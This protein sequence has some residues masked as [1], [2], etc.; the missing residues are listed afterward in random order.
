M[1][2]MENEHIGPFTDQLRFM[3]AGDPLRRMAAYRLSLDLVDMAW[4]DAQAIRRSSTTKPIASQ[5]Y[6]AAGSIGA[7][8]AEGYSRSSGRDR[9]RLF[10]YALGSARECRHWY[11][12]SRY[13]LAPRTCE[14]QSELLGRVCRILLAAIPEERDRAIRSSPKASG[15]P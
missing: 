3:G 7:N 4:P 10:E 1:S 9:V 15:E 11:Y 8:I 12:A 2:V 14:A 6:R 13:V 5:L